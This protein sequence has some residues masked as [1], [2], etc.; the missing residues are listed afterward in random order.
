M[1]GA[2]EEGRGGQAEGR[3]APNRSALGVRT[4]SQLPPPPPP[5]PPLPRGV[6][7]L[8]PS[9]PPLLLPPVLPPQPP[10]VPASLRSSQ[11]ER[12]GANP[13]LPG[14][15]FSSSLAPRELDRGESTAWPFRP[16]EGSPGGETLSS[17][18]DCPAPPEALLLSSGPCARRARKAQTPVSESIL[19]CRRPRGFQDRP[20]SPLQLGCSPS[21]ELIRFDTAVAQCNGLLGFIFW[22][23]TRS[24]LGEMSVTTSD[25][26]QVQDPKLNT[27][28]AS[29]LRKGQW[30][31]TACKAYFILLG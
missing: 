9:P 28:V 4:P 11:R 5:P 16:S 25:K 8:P 30:D 23:Q 20:P 19:T 24:L 21:A 31:W 6:M 3:V 26:P 18:S 10:L 15:P 13:P 1:A 27:N 7:G 14:G 2:R 12:S 22:D 29:L 17:G